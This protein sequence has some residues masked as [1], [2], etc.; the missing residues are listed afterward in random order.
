MIEIPVLISH[1]TH[2]MKFKL[3]FSLLRIFKLK[4][5]TV[6]LWVPKQK[7]SIVHLYSLNQLLTVSVI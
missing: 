6:L 7:L 2:S 1:I 3:L 5:T 4:R